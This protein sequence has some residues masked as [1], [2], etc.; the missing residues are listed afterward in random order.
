MQKELNSNYKL[1]YLDGVRAL[2]AIYIVMHHAV[3]QYYEMDVKNLAGL[4]GLKK[5][6]IL[7]FFQG[8]LS[9]D[10]FIVLS[11]F[12]LMLPVIRGNYQLKGGAILFYKKRLIRIIPP[13]F[14]AM[15]V[16]IVLIWLFIGQKTGTHW[17]VSIPFTY[18]DVIAHVLLIHD[19][20]SSHGAKINHA[21]W[22]IAVECR[23]YVLFPLMV[24][25]WRKIGWLYSVLITIVISYLLYTGM[26]YA[27][28]F[29]PDINLSTPGVNPY[30][31]LFALGML[32]AD[33]SFAS[34]K[35]A[36]WKNKM[37]WMLL[38][39]MSIILYII[40][41]KV[42]DRWVINPDAFSRELIDIMFGLCCFL[43][44]IISSKAQYINTGA[45]NWLYKI[46]S[47]QPL[48]F[49][50]SFA[51][52]IYLIHAPLVQI[53]TEYFISPLHLSR[54]VSTMVAVLVALVLIMPLSYLFFVFCER[55]FMRMGKKMS[56]RDTEL[57]AVINPAP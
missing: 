22:S 25:L 54:Y 40:V 35:F 3:L 56:V 14:F 7:V 55:P 24:F 10:L 48:V 41:W 50:G 51:Y 9:V 8:R 38:F 17:D 28:H 33:I 45:Y 16:S 13:Y 20:F 2:A 12:C 11:G 32:A 1:L 53:I 15:L 34:N 44:L 47:W 5:L 43:L 26:L 39:A 36:A 21:F 42:I 27:Q 29:Y 52:S 30:L 57:T 23:I 19:V 37:P 18:K 49:V 46:L 6:S 31:I 4:T